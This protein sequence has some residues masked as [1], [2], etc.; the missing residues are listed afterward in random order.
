MKKEEK[1]KKSFGEKGEEYACAYLKNEGFVITER[2][3]RYGHGEIDIVARDGETLVF[4]EV[5][6]RASLEYGR[7][8][9][10]VTKSKQKQIRKIAE[11]YLF[12]KNIKDTEC[13][14]DVVAILFHGDRKPEVNHIKNAF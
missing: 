9:F 10:A 11:A 12:E 7:P 2:N 1:P 6:S 3:Y 8:E 13:R 14:M 4:V 5:K